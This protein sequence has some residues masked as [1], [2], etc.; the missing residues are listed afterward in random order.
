MLYQYCF[1]HF[2]THKETENSSATGE[3][4]E[5]KKEESHNLNTKKIVKEED[6][7]KEVS[8]KKEVEA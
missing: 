8:A 4:K 1:I 6:V 2:R 7:K 5:E 3:L